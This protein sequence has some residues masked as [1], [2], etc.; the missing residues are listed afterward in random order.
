MK[1]CL[2][3]IAM[4]TSGGL[5]VT[6]LESGELDTELVMTDGKVKRIHN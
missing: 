3:A 1:V 2:K 5:A 4:G 6:A